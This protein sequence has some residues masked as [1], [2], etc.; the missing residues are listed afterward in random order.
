[1]AKA[2][3]LK[4]SDDKM[5]VS[6]F[7]SEGVRVFNNATSLEGET[8]YSW[9]IVN[10]NTQE[11]VFKQPFTANPVF[12]HS[13]EQFKNMDVVARIRGGVELSC[14]V[15]EAEQRE[16]PEIKMMYA[17][18]SNFFRFTNITDA[19]GVHFGWQVQVRVK[20]HWEDVCLLENQ[21]TNIFEYTFETGKDYRVTAFIGSDD[22][23]Y[24][25]RLVAEISSTDLELPK[26][27]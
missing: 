12:A 25:T 11:I 9:D 26:I 15:F 18:R 5:A 17:R 20:R 2:R 8:L 14:R 7:V 16:L 27:I 24:S 22:G 10:P 3:K 13:V 19:E 4:Y 23:G 1:M 6:S 21:K